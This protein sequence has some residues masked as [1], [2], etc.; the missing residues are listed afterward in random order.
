MTLAAHSAELQNVSALLFVECCIC[1]ESV[2]HCQDYHA[3]L[4]QTHMEEGGTTATCPHCR[5]G[6]NWFES[7]DLFVQH[8]YS[9]TRFRFNCPVCP[10]KVSARHSLSCHVRLQHKIKT[11][12]RYRQCHV[13]GVQQEGS[14]EL[15]KHLLDQHVDRDQLSCFMCAEQTETASK[16]AHH[17]YSHAYAVAPAKVCDV[18]G[19]KFGRTC[20]LQLHMKMAHEDLP[21]F[22][23]DVCGK[24]YKSDR[25]LQMHKLR[26]TMERKI[27]CGDC[28]KM[29]YTERDL[30]SHVRQ[31]SE[32]LSRSYRCNHCEKGFLN[33][34]VLKE[35]IQVRHTGERSFACDMCERSYFRRRELVEHQRSHTGEKP[36]SCEICLRMYQRKTTL[37][38]H[39][40]THRE[41][42]T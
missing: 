1:L 40:K 24:S 10:T 36:F 21:R 20:S 4:V 27:K 25:Y 34:S 14:A 19:K 33:M 35:H 17:L 32:E 42:A 7:A 39:M 29:F 31:H 37:L 18:C 28:D 8:M 26:H 2:A 11:G 12:I 22:V 38:T 9:H 13:C 30:K 15:V 23:C 5:E 6:S 16:L 3:H 41:K